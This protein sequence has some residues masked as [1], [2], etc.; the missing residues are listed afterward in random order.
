MPKG[1]HKGKVKHYV[2]SEE[3]E[4]AE[5]KRQRELE[6][7]RKKGL[8]DDEEKDKEGDSSG[9]EED[10]KGDVKGAQSKPPRD[11]PP[12]DDSEEEEDEEEEEEVVPK[13]KGVESLIEVENPNRLPP[14]IQNVK[15][16]DVDA[17]VELSR[18]EREELE[19]QR[20]QAAYNKLHE[21]E[22]R[23]SSQT[24]GSRKSWGRRQALMNS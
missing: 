6:W 15:N 5:Q 10:K 4:E 19:Q 13:A 7:K 8:P 24:Q 18:R 17:K 1:K 22:R 23:S 2:T 20:K 9:E 14:K 21:K 11:M 16:V 3:V 12:S